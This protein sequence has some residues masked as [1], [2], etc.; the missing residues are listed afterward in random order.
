M[1]QPVWLWYAILPPSTPSP[2]DN[3]LVAGLGF[4]VL[5]VILVK[6]EMLPAAVVCRQWEEAWGVQDLV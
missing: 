5:V 3:L 4:I 6:V 2:G 1:G